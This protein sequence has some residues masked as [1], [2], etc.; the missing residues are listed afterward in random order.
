MTSIYSEFP[1]FLSPS[2]EN[3]SFFL[4][5]DIGSENDFPLLTDES[6][7]NYSIQ[8]AGKLQK[9]FHGDNLQNNL[10]IQ[11][12]F[13]NFNHSYTKKEEEEEN[14]KLYYIEKSE[15]SRQIVKFMTKEENN[16]SKSESNE[17]L[18]KKR[19]RERIN[20]KNSNSKIHDKFSTDNLLRKIQVHYLTFIVAFLNEILAKMKIKERFLKLGYE[21]K[22][23]VN[24]KYVESLKKQSIGEIICNKISIKYRKQDEDANRKIYE[25]IKGNEVLNKIL[26][27]NYLKLFKKIYYKNKT[28]TINL[29]EYGLDETIVLSKKVKMFKDLL[30]D[31]EALDVNKEYIK[32]IKECA[33]HNFIPDFMFLPD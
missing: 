11:S 21:V 27:E 6:S 14:K 30:K 9:D 17:I 12:P 2:L 1:T 5:Q 16:S 20:I 13:Q 29:K 4:I 10:I 31:N 26:S 7:S 3:E 28:N 33:I 22:K 32:K 19:G 15:K 25:I 24:N 18:K 8:N 23:N